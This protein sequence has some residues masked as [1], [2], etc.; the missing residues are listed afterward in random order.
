AASGE[1]GLSLIQAWNLAV[2]AVDSLGLVANLSDLSGDPGQDDPGQ[3]GAW[4]CKLSYSSDGTTTAHMVG[5]GKGHAPVARVGALYEAWESSLTGPDSFPYEAAVAESA[6]R[7]ATARALRQAAPAA[8]LVDG[9]DMPIPCLRYRALTDDSTI[10]APIFLAAP[11]YTGDDYLQQRRE[12]RDDFDYRS[13][14][15]HCL[16]NGCAVGASLAEAAVHGINE[17]I[18]RDALSMFLIRAF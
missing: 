10:S 9:P 1:R 14:R 11:W 16:S 2:G 5:G 18:E 7:V 8:L 17:V 6:H 13:V 4:K 3:L 15:R 12:L